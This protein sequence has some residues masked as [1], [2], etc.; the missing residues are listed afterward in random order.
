MT[1]CV[2]IL[3][4]CVALASPSNDSGSRRKFFFFV[5]DPLCVPRAKYLL[6]TYC[7]N[8]SE[9]NVLTIERNTRKRNRRNVLGFHRRIPLMN[10]ASGFFFRRRIHRFSV[11]FSSNPRFTHSSGLNVLEAK[12]FK[13]P[14]QSRHLL[15]IRQI[16]CALPG[17]QKQKTNSMFTVVRGF[18]MF[19]LVRRF[20]YGRWSFFSGWNHMLRS[21]AAKHF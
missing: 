8:V 5:L 6:T 14:L 21:Y 18:Q 9:S 2:K 3:T 7:W 10:V 19:V 20:S 12:F 4:F 15:R 1:P 11:L 13:I 16:M 17:K